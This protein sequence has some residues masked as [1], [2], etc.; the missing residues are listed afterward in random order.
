MRR[1]KSL[2]KLIL[3]EFLLGSLKRRFPF[4]KDAAHPW[5][6]VPKL[7]ALLTKVSEKTDLA[8]DD[9]G[10]LGDPMD[11]RGDVLVKRAW[12]ASS[13]GLKASPS[14]YMHCQKLGVLV[15]TVSLTGRHV[16]AATT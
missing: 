3:L 13:I 1:H 2:V 5:N 8:F 7:D 4:E 15:N 6:K 14:S 11:K 9:L 12:D 16:Q 10:S